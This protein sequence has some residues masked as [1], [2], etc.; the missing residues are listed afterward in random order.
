MCCWINDLHSNFWMLVCCV[1]LNTR[2]HVQTSSCFSWLIIICCQM[3]RKSERFMPRD[4]CRSIVRQNWNTEIPL[5]S[6]VH[7][8]PVDHQGKYCNKNVML[9]PVHADSGTQ[10]RGHRQ[11]SSVWNHSNTD[12]NEEWE[13][14]NLI[15]INAKSG[16]SDR[17]YYLKLPLYGDVDGLVISPVFS[18]SHSPPDW[19]Q[20]SV[21]LF[22]RYDSKS[23][24]LYCFF[25]SFLFPFLSIQAADW[26]VP[27][28]KQVRMVFWLM[29]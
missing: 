10:K 15:F 11:D 28:N 18:L 3:I 2:R 22:P 5:V 29:I 17:P 12:K 16:K 25:W 8:N 24:L 26:E 7:S 6:D 20:R 19:L 23:W 21:F 14:P 13:V 9:S 27:L 4:S 1:V